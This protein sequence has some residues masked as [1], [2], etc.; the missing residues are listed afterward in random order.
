[1][2]QIA[3]SKSMWLFESRPSSHDELVAY[4]LSHPEIIWNLI[5][6]DMRSFAVKSLETESVI[7]GF[8]RG[9][10]EGFIDI[11]ATVVERCCSC[12][13]LGIRKKVVIEVKSNKE[14]W[15]AGDVI[16]QLKKYSHLLDTP[17][18]GT[19]CGDPARCESCKSCKS[20]A[21]SYGN[22]LV[23]VCARE[24]NE[25]EEMLFKCASIYTLRI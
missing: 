16:R 17:P 7:L 10:I 14:N 3:K 12:K 2:S 22:M 1:M 8:R 9:V 4:V 25:H 15:T 20:E 13:V 11:L 19:G 18:N 6:D 24:I 5:K 21:H 23:L